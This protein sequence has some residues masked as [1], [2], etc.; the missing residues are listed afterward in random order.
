MSVI[1]QIETVARRIRRFKEIQAEYS[2]DEF[3]GGG[4]EG[5]DLLHLTR[6]MYE[7]AFD[8]LEIPETLVEKADEAQ[9]EMDI[10]LG[11]DKDE[12]GFPIPRSNKSEHKDKYLELFSKCEEVER[13]LYDILVG[14]AKQRGIT[15][16]VEK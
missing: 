9:R 2:K 8:G 12:F 15:V 3:E 11:N 5:N 14:Y 4:F 13:E 7:R 16:D 10:L 1:K 6:G